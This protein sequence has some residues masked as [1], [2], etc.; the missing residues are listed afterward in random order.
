MKKDAH[1]DHLEIRNSNLENECALHMEK[2]GFKNVPLP[3]DV[4]GKLVKFSARSFSRKATSE[5]FT[6]WYHASITDDGKL[7]VTYNSHHDSLK[8]D[9]HYVFTSGANNGIH[10]NEVQAMRQRVAKMQE[11]RERTEK[12][13]EASRRK[14]AERDRIRF[15]KALENGSSQY[16]E[17]KKV[18]IHGVRFE[19]DEKKQE[20]IIL[21]PMRDENSN[22]QALQEIFETK[23][24]FAEGV[25]PRDKNF[26]N[27]T[28]GLFHIIGNIID[29]QQIRVSEGFAT[30]ASCYESTGFAIPHVVA[31]SAGAYKTVIPILRKLYPNSHILICA[32]DN[33][34]DDPIKINTGVRFAEQVATEVSNCSFV[35]PIFPA[36]GDKDQK[37]N[38]Y[39]DFNDLMLVVG[40]EEVKKQ[41]EG[42]EHPPE[43]PSSL[44]DI[45]DLSL[46]EG[47]EVDGA[48]KVR[49][50]A[51]RRALMSGLNHHEIVS[52]LRKQY[53]ILR[54]QAEDIAT[55]ALLW[56]KEYEINSLVN[57]RGI[58]KKITDMA[59]LDL[60]FAQLEAPG[61]PCLTIHRPDAQPISHPDFLKRL[62]GEVIIS[63]VDSKG[64]P[65]Y[66]PA[67]TFW[68]GSAQ[69]LI[70]RSIAFTSKP[71]G[72]DVYNLFTGFGVKPKSGECNR[73]L[74]HIRDV[75]CSGCE[76]NYIAL[77]KLLSWQIQNIGKPSRI[78]VALKSKMQ[79]VGKGC[80]LSDVLAVIYGTSGF[81]TSDLGKIVTR[82]ND[83]IRGNAYIFLD[84][85]LF[86]GDR[87]AADA[88][89]SL[90][91]ATYMG[92]ESKGIPT[93]QLP[94]A[95]N[96]FLA[97][98]HD[99]AA[100]IEES[101]V[102]YWILEVSP[103]RAGDVEY[104]QELYAEIED[105]GRE[106]FMYHLLNYDIQDF[107]PWR[108]V[109]KDNEFK[110][111]MIRNSIN[112]Y[113]ARRW[114]EEC[115]RAEMIL[116]MAPSAADLNLP[117]ESWQ[118]GREYINGVFQTAYT[119]WQKTV[120]SPV[121][122]KPTA[123]NKFGELLNKA[124]LEMR[125]AGDRRRTLPDAQECLEIVLEMIEKEGI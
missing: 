55:K 71:V 48:L 107:V 98:N 116:G 81:V 35:Y 4:S 122:P 12:K 80:L 37:G 20:K 34:Q 85:A 103:H 114:L 38:R 39:A 18:G 63:G 10:E 97:T 76:K 68:D 51:R 43:K 78:I 117:W 124:G 25:K 27:S 66:L 16:I 104:F 93:M 106:A 73:V 69:K 84:E 110:D 57:L 79:Q 21:V 94:V 108:D 112:P 74:A 46:E 40:K 13:K 77:I 118:K 100:H 30:A 102:R 42:V 47:E 9:K 24:T 45:C 115:C 67:S 31:F 120:N 125:I 33:K 105:G 96:L 86:S 89:K 99:D 123:I 36:D 5:D 101:D 88:I 61:Q 2:N 72:N 23:R 17:R 109:P 87:K 15:N 50:S 26:T 44:L 121:A 53:S 113:D 83:T 62:S 41:I 52:D 22:I 6:E 58:P 8:R 119:N 82:F 7:L 19:W 91:T 56:A 65:K 29:G 14:N 64:Q 1:S 60:R 95:I 54:D 49:A 11:E 75:V 70:F 111:A 28:K 32:D 3:L 90:A 92:I 59:S